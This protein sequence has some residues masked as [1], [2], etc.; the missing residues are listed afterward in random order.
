VK[1]ESVNAVTKVV[2]FTD[3]GVQE[4]GRQVAVEGAKDATA[5]AD[6]RHRETRQSSVSI[7][8]Q[9]LIE[10]I[11]EANKALKGADKRF[12]FSIHEGTKE[13][14]VKVINDETDEIIRE[15]PPE[16]ILDMVAKIWE[17]AGILVDRKI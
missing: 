1:V 4:S 5:V 12:E 15:I 13:I 16:K 10:A 3:I 8:E 2:R 7:S 14:M 9:Q 11:E 6:N 17:M